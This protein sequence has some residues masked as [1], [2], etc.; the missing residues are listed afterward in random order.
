MSDEQTSKDF[1]LEDLEKPLTEKEMK[2]TTGGEGNFGP[3]LFGKTLIFFFSCFRQDT[4]SGSMPR[5]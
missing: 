2:E 4:V 1:E 3:S 5:T